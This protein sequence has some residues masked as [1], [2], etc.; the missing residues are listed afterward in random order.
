MNPYK[1]PPAVGYGSPLAAK[2]NNLK[3]L[4]AYLD[5]KQGQKNEKALNQELYVKENA[6]QNSKS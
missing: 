5:I 3:G 2:G 4:S 6:E 1:S